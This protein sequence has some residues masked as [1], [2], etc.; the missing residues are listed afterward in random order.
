MI[1]E[2]VVRHLL[3]SLINFAGIL[4][5]SVQLLHFYT[6]HN[7]FYSHASFGYVSADKVDLTL[8]A[9]DGAKGTESD[10]RDSEEDQGSRNRSLQQRR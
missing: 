9:D 6:Y 10:T 3:F 2:E 8:L 7:L 5:L 1:Y 4:S